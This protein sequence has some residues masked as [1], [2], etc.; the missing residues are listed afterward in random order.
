[1]FLFLKEFVFLPLCVGSAIGTGPGV[2]QVD[3]FVP[4]YAEG[5]RGGKFSRG[6]LGRSNANQWSPGV[7]FFLLWNCL[8]EYCLM[9]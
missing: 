3:N 8:F 9:Y 4:N 5:R 2:I 6:G 1:M 7:L